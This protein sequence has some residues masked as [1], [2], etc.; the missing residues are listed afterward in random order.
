VLACGLDW[1]IFAAWVSIESVLMLEYGLV[2]GTGE[3]IAGWGVH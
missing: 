1:E 2:A 3:H